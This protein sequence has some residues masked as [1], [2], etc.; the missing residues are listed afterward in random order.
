LHG[1]VDADHAGCPE[2]RRSVSGYVHILNGAA[3]SWASKRQNS[4]ALSS[5][6][7][8]FYAASLA[9]CDVEYLR[10]VMRDLGFEQQSPTVLY[11][12]NQACIYLSKHKTHFFKSKHIDTR[13]HRL[14]DL[15][16]NKT[17]KLHHISTH[18]QV[19]DALTKGLPFPLF[20]RHRS[21]MLGVP[22]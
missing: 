15:T 17:L 6:E 5:T 22:V 2:T 12:D 1:F 19:A 4:V 16:E 10:F 8:E 7:A 9:A 18:F 20:E 21:V 13:A 14:R 3:V 11:E